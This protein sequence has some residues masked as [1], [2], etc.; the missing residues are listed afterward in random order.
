MELPVEERVELV[1]PYLIRSGLIKTPIM[2]K[3]REQVAQVVVAAGDR[4][5]V[6]GDILDFDYFFIPDE[7]LEID[8][9]AFKSW[10]GSKEQLNLLT[11]V[12]KVLARVERFERDVLESTLN[13]FAAEKGVKPMTISQVLRVATTGRDFGFGIYD[14]LTILGKER[15]TARIERV[16]KYAI[17]NAK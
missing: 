10:L 3:I 12:N 11:D 5:K 14:C 1:L 6:A 17:Q 9:K 15:V 4:I 7:Q 2:P 13:H 16:L 8:E